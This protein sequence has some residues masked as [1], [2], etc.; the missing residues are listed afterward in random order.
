MPGKNQGWTI[1]ASNWHR[2]RYLFNQHLYAAP[3]V[4]KKL[5]AQLSGANVLVP[6]MSLKIQPGKIAK[7]RQSHARLRLK[8]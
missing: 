2:E 6:V 1:I 7:F 8:P 4:A 5:I 3:I